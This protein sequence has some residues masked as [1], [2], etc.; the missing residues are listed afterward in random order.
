[1]ESNTAQK[2]SQSAAYPHF[3]NL[4]S[5]SYM[6]HPFLNREKLEQLPRALNL[7][8]EAVESVTQAYFSSPKISL[9]SLLLDSFSNF[10]STSS[11]GVQLHPAT[12]PLPEL[13]DGVE[14]KLSRI[15]GKYE[16]I[17]QQVFLVQ[18]LSDAGV[19]N[20][21]HMAGRRKEERSGEIT[22]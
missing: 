7:P 20:V 14:A 4:P 21:C 12:V 13:D 10:K 18:N 1:M 5:S 6:Y 22:S 11:N 15:E 19:H 9:L 17:L 16:K 3:T 8:D 2:L